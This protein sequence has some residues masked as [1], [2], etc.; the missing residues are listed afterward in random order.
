MH[1]YENNSRDLESNPSPLN[2][3]PNAFTVSPPCGYIRFE[4]K[5]INIF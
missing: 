5:S 4:Y 2:Y 1:P 3:N